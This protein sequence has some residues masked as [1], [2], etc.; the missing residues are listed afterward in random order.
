MAR[1]YQVAVVGAG[2]VGLA[3][4]LAA[5]RRGLSVVVIDRDAQANGASIR[6]FGFVTVTGQPRGNIWS[7]AHRTRAVWDEI[8]CEADVSILQRGLWLPVR[9][10]EAA[11]VL[12]AFMAT[13]MGEGCRLMT[14]G[15]ARARA[16]EII[17]PDTVAALW[18]PHDLR[19]DSRSAIPRLAA[20][21]AARFGVEFL[22]QT[23]VQAVE[24]P[25]VLTSRGIIEAERIVVCPGDDLV[26]LFPDYMTDA[27]LARCK[28]Q[29][30]RLAS[31][32]FVLPAPIMSDLGLVR[33]GGYADL[34]EAAALR[35]RLEAEQGQALADG[36][37]LI[38][39]Q[40]ADGALVVGDSHHDAA[41]P[42][43]FASAAVDQLI[44]DEW[45]AATGRPAPAVLQRWTGTYA[46]GPK[47]DLI[48]APHPDVRLALITAGN[49][50]STG[51]AFG[52]AVISDLFQ[53]TFKP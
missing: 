39:V 31:P 47:A 46:Y 17:G 12:E 36:V 15:E 26:S 52:E 3:C 49:G 23:A 41:T 19:V 33:Y 22:R 45:H 50:A 28:L 42:D 32:G 24:P 4:A 16:P 2:I 25:R 14:A 9:R 5:A 11:A 8:A 20:W 40:D 44:L 43:P 30:M 51:F 48:A 10:P 29:M 18:S 34:P 27:G 53:E 35:A 1:R 37:H 6:N 7:R 13:E 38:A 21:L